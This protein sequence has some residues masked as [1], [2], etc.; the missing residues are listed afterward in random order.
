MAGVAGKLYLLGG[1]VRLGTT[2]VELNKLYVY[3]PAVGGDGSWSTS[4][5]LNAPTGDRA[6]GLATDLGGQLLLF[7]GFETQIWANDLSSF[8]AVSYKW[9]AHAPQGL[10]PSPRSSAAGAVLDG[11]WYVT[12]GTGGPF[13]DT[14]AL[15]DSLY[16]Y[17]P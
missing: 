16:I 6:Y 12:G 5:S 13:I 10:V 3:D 15:G 4:P 17:T 11:K 7:G 9:T 1:F 8:D 2:Q 14:V